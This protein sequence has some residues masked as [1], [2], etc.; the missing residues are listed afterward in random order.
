MSSSRVCT[1]VCAFYLVILITV[2]NINYIWIWKAISQ[3]LNKKIKKNYENE[4]KKTEQT[5]LLACVVYYSFEYVAVCTSW[6][7]GQCKLFIATNLI[8]CIALVY[9]SSSLNKND[10]FVEN[11]L[12][13]GCSFIQSFIHSLLIKLWIKSNS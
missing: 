10:A 8:Y 7:D 13:N 2:P 12:A 5:L 11:L 6:K 1:M 3:W 9:V 4:Q